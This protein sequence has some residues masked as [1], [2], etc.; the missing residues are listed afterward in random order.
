MTIAGYF[1]KAIPSI[2]KAWDHFQAGER[3][4][5]IRLDNMSN[6][7]LRRPKWY[8][9][10][11]IVDA[12]PPFRILSGESAIVIFRKKPSRFSFELKDC[13]YLYDC[14]SACVCVVCC[15]RVC[16]ADCYLQICECVRF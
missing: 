6:K 9:K 7:K 11:G 15:V 3:W 12:L 2:K 1:L 4:V 13:S 14:L 10:S 16:G 5:A 8:M